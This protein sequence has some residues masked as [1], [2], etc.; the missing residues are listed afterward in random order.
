MFGAQFKMKLH[1]LTVEHL[2]TFCPFQADSGVNI[3]CMNMFMNMNFK[4]FNMLFL[5]DF[6]KLHEKDYYIVHAAGHTEET[7]E[8]ST[9]ASVGL[10]RVKQNYLEV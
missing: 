10:D 1:T 8:G 2:W 3:F 7:N 5:T 6:R 4:P 9:P